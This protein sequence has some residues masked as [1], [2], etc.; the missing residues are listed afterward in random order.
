MKPP[1]WD[2]WF[3]VGH[4]AYDGFAYPA[5]NNGAWQY[6]EETDGDYL[7]DVL[8]AEA[9]EF[10]DSNLAD[11]PFFL[12]VT[13]MAPHAPA[14]PARR[15]QPPLYDGEMYP[16]DNSVPLNPSFNEDDVDDKPLYIK[17]L[18]KF[19]PTRVN[20]IHDR[21]RDRLRCMASVAD[22]VV[23]IV[24]KLDELDPGLENT[25]V[26]FTSDHGFHM[27]EHRLGRD[28]FQDDVTPPVPGGKNSM[29]EEDIR[30]PL[31][32]RGP[33]IDADTTVTELVGNV[34]LAPTFLDIAGLAPDPDVDGRS[35]KPLLEGSTVPWRNKYLITRG[36]TKPYRG[37]RMADETVF[38]ELLTPA[39]LEVQGEYYNLVADPYQLENGYLGLKPTPLAGLRAKVG[40][41]ATCAG[42]TCRTADSS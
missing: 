33:G 38:A 42:S 17:N 8:A 11:E 27:G 2:W 29:Y 9:I 34:D 13:P 32:V 24:D 23:A 35:F 7:T 28:E 12:L 4:A 10:L 18:N 37:I 39:P 16:T 22:M 25:Y 20:Q 26:F 41:Y 1:G 19:G 31:W 15:H 21:Y 40:A 3:A 30:V 14:V 6:F 36:Q 5:N